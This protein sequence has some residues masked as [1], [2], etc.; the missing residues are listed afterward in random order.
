L[1]PSHSR[2]VPC[3]GSL[4]VAGAPGLVLE[5]EDEVQEQ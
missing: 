3:A 4:A 2:H 1:A 5:D